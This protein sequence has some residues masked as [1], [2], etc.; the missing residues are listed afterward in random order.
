[1][2]STHLPYIHMHVY[3]VYDTI[4]HHVQMYILGVF[5][6]RNSPIIIMLLMLYIYIYVVP[7]I[8]Q[9]TIKYVA[10]FHCVHYSIQCLVDTLLT[11]STYIKINFSIFFF[12]K[13]NIFTV[14]Q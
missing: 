1:M 3:C 2:Y 9:N 10:T 7:C 5:D 13:D 11:V 6:N 8:Y 12:T 4:M 14:N